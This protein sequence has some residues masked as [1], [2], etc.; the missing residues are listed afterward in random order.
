MSADGIFF[1]YSDVNLKDVSDGASQTL[2]FGERFHYDPEFDRR[3]AVLAP[4]VPGID[5]FGHWGFVGNHGGIMADITLHSAVT[6]N[7]QVPPN[8]DEAEL[9]NRACAFGSG[10]PGGA[11]FAFADGSARFVAENFSLQQLQALS[12]RADGEVVKRP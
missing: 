5:A 6:I 12:T 10:H 2:L 3:M 1:L 11:N 7:F 4:D 9:V 8:G